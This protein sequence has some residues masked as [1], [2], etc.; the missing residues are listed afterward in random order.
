MRVQTVRVRKPAQRCW[1][2]VEHAVHEPARTAGV[3]DE[4]GGDAERV[5]VARPCEHRARP[6]LVEGIERGVVEIHDALRLRLTNQRVIEIRA[7]PVRIADFVERACGDHQLPIVLFGVGEGVAGLMEE[8]RE[9]AFQP[10]GDVW[11]FALPRTPFGKCPDARQV[12]AIR[13]L[14]Q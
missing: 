5:T 12:V 14:L 7:I 1:F 10:A 4:A 6:G 8:E 3:D 11:M 13:E 2:K 9:P